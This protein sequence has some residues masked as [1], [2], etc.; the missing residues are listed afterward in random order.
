MAWYEIL[1]IAAAAC[2]V[3]GVAAWRIV[4]RKQGKGGCDCGRGCGGNCP[5]CAQGKKEK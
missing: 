1:L 5:H 3:V 2:F 4:R